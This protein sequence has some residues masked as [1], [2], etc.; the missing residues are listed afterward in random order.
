MNDR[1]TRRIPFIAAPVW[2]QLFSFQ[3]S[4]VFQMAR[5]AVRARG[6][7]VPRSYRGRKV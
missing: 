4:F 3:Q 2:R 1:K 6:S 7:I 5:K